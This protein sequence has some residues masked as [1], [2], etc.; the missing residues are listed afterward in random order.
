MRSTRQIAL[1]ESGQEYALKLVDILERVNDAHTS[2]TAI[3]HAPQGVLRVHARVMFG[4]GV[5]PPLLA[6][7]RKLYPRIRVELALTEVAVDLRRD[8]FDIDFR[9]APPVEAGI[10]RRKLFQGER[11]LVA[12][13]RY[14]LKRPA[15]ATPSSVLLHDCL[16][17]EIPG[18]AH[19]WWFRPRGGLQD[20]ECIAFTP[21]HVSNNGIA[22]LELARMGEGLVLLDDYTVHDDLREGRLVRVLD[23]FDISNRNSFEDGMYV[24]I[25]DTDII[26]AKIRLFVD[27]VAEHVAGPQ[28]RFAAHRPARTHTNTPS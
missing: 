8:G 5:L 19:A 25:L 26:P 20:A 10:K 18:N 14:L 23:G 7:F 4:L 24:T 21:R 11:H 2:I 9:V 22:L 28:L 12:A 1:T 16:S 13:P 6:G 27:Y 15:L 17:Y 3:S